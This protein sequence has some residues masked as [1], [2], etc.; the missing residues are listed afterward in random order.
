MVQAVLFNPLGSQLHSNAGNTKPRE[1]LEPI[2]G[3]TGVWVEE[4]YNFTYKNI[5]D[6]AVCLTV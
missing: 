4:K 3:S 2:I 1:H 5:Y 6:A